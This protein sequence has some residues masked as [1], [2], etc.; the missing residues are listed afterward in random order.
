MVVNDVIYERTKAILAKLYG[1][2]AVRSAFSA[3]KRVFLV[4]RYVKTQS[5][6]TTQSD[7]SH[8]FGCQKHKNLW[9][10]SSW[11]SSCSK[12]EHAVKCSAVDCC[13]RL[14][15]SPQ[16]SLWKPAWQT[17][18]SYGS[19]RKEAKTLQLLPYRV[20]VTQQVLLLSDCEWLLAKLGDELRMLELIS[21]PRCGAAPTYR[22]RW[23]SEY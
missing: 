2:Y 14:S 3:E 20:H 22:P 18:M 5:L 15:A 1:Q 4:K 11:N 6:K 23:L 13:E 17:E 19:C 9:Y 12:C 21:F 16:E 10:G 7:Y 8:R